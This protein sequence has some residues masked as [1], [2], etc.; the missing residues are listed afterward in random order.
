MSKGNTPAVWAASNIKKISYFSQ[1]LATFSTAISVPD[2]LD[3]CCITT[4]FV[5]D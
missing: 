2:T 1:I 3:P 4:A 5:F